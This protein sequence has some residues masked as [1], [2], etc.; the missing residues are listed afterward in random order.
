MGTLIIWGYLWGY[1]FIL[2]INNLENTVLAG[3]HYVE[4]AKSTKTRRLSSLA[5]FFM[6]VRFN[7][8]Q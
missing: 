7:E 3:Q 5:G 8:M 1:L 6:P 4:P 2:D